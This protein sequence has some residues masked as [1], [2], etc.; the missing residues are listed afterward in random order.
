[1]GLQFRFPLCSDFTE[2]LLT[3]DHTFILYCILNSLWF[4]RTP[5]LK[6]RF[7][8]V[9]SKVLRK[10]PLYTFFTIEEQKLQNRRKSLHYKSFYL[11]NCFK[12]ILLEFKWS[13]MVFLLPKISSDLIVYGMLR[14]CYSFIC[15]IF[16]THPT[17]L[18]SQTTDIHIKLRT[19]VK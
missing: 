3:I 18:L 19:P 13:N 9:K 15:N 17:E 11:V 7:A 10:K 8:V 1:M 4:L 5:R 2:I 14:S 16:K 6:I 12:E